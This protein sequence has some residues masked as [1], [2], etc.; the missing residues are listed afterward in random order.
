MGYGIR[1]YR[2]RNPEFATWHR[3]LAN[4]RQASGMYAVFARLMIDSFD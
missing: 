2:P 4:V 3:R 1:R